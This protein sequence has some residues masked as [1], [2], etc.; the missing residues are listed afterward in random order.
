MP[1]R[2]SSSRSTNYEA[3]KF[4]DRTGA[5][6]GTPCRARWSFRRPS[7][8][9]SGW[10]PAGRGAGRRGSRSGCRRQPRSAPPAPKQIT[11]ARRTRRAERV[12]RTPHAP[13]H[14]P[15]RA[16][17]RSIGGSIHMECIGKKAKKGLLHAALVPSVE[18]CLGSVREHVD[19]HAGLFWFAFSIQ[20]P[21]VCLAPATVKKQSTRPWDFQG[22]SQRT[23]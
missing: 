11:R 17:T 21:S 9:S 18:P 23:S 16:P 14:T 10:R 12:A 20:A 2:T 3:G 1:G 7:L 15:A 5:R 22:M 4:L 19:V 13:R 6:N 8:Q